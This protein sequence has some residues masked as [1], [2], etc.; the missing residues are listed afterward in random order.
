MLACREC[1]QNIGSC[2]EM[3]REKHSCHGFRT[4]N[5][6]GQRLQQSPRAQQLTMVIC[7]IQRSLICV[8]VIIPT[9]PDQHE[10]DMLSINAIKEDDLWNRKSVHLHFGRF[11]FRPLLDEMSLL[12][13]IETPKG[14]RGPGSSGSDIL[15]AYRQLAV[16]IF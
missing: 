8:G 13:N 14:H 9:A 7:N 2:P 5:H 15:F 6:I 12:P 4:I 16:C 3:R 10:C 1:R 11:F